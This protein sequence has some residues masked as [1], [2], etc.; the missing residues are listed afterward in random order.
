MKDVTVRHNVLKESIKNY[1]NRSSPVQIIKGV[2][3]MGKTSIISQVFDNLSDED[4]DF[5]SEEF[6]TKKEKL[7][8]WKSSYKLCISYS[9]Y[10]STTPLIFPE[11]DIDFSVNFFNPFKQKNVGWYEDHLLSNPI[12]EFSEEKIPIPLLYPEPIGEFLGFGESG[13]AYFHPYTQSNITIQEVSDFIE[14]D[15]ELRALLIE[16]LRKAN[17]IICREY[18]EAFHSDHFSYSFTPS[19]HEEYEYFDLITTIKD[20]E[21]FVSEKTNSLNLASSSYKKIF[22]E[23]IKQF[24]YDSC[25]AQ[26][27]PKTL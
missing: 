10:C 17:E 4:L 23:F 25:T 7:D 16:K 24:S 13:E 3:S 6:F 2:G 9:S 8:S 20:N 18:Q 19:F 15:E 12:L 5:N 27:C 1:F 26:S 22:Y 21:E 11:L 14:N